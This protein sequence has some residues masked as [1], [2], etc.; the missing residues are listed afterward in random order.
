MNVFGIGGWELVLVLIIMLVVAGPKR[1][2]QWAYTLGRWTAKLRV[3]WEEVAESLQAELKESGFDV[4]IPKTPPTRQSIQRSLEDYGKQIAESAGNP[5]NELNK[6]RED[7]EGAGKDVKKDLDEIDRSVKGAVSR[8][9]VKQ[10]SGAPPSD[11][12]T[13]SKD[14]DENSSEFGT[15]GG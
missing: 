14:D 7:I 11:G 6:I 3:M 2:A 8:N 15:W 13:S 12:T 9:G 10:T 1:M 4:E 5:Q